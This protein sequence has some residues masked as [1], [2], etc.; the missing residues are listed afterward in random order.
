MNWCALIAGALAVLYGVI[1]GVFVVVGGA[2]LAGADTLDPVG[3]VVFLALVVISGL[4][5]TGGV[6]LLARRASGQWTVVAGAVLSIGGISYVLLR[7]ST[8]PMGVTPELAASANT[9]L[10]QIAVVALVLAI[11][12]LALALVPRREQGSRPPTW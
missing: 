11:V 2:E 3:A 1:G 4:L 8:A 12:M 6:L 9:E 5:L 7:T 10:R